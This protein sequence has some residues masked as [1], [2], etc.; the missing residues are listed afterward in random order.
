MRGSNRPTIRDVAERA[1]VSKSLVSLVLRDAPHVSDAKRA[2]VH[3]AID[4]LGYRPNAVA[5]SLVRRRTRVLGL[6]IDDIHNPF[7]ADMVGGIDPAARAAGYAT[8]INSGSR[9]VTREAAALETMLELRVD[10]I[11]MAGSRLETRRIAGTARTVPIALLTRTVRLGSIDTVVN[12]DFSGAR[13]AVD[14]LVALGHRRIAHVDGGREP[15]GPSRRRGYERAME[16]HGLERFV[17]VA[18][19]AFTEDGGARGTRKLLEASSPPT[20]IFAG[21]DQAAL[22]AFAALDDAGLRVPEDVSLVGY[23]NTSVAALRHISLTTIN[24]PRAE[25]GERAVELLVE[26]IDGGRT[27]ALHVVMEPTLVE[28]ATTAP[29]RG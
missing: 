5:R 29:P 27:E 25:M 21:N 22:G 15:G 1:G 14:H 28:R 26:R 24:Q 18:K 4:E 17:K 6:L 19:G 3:K 8:F 16:A 10:G 20:A 9:S 7:F 12:D 23:D 11:I 13:L 2:A